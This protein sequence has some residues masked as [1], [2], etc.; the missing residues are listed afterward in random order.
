VGAVLL[1][2]AP[3][4]A[5]VLATGPAAGAGTP[6][7]ESHLI[8]KRAHGKAAID[9]LGSHLEV[10]AA[11]SSMTP[12]RLR[13]VLAEDSSAWVDVTGHLFYVERDHAADD[14]VAIPESTTES[15]T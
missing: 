13:R 8:A 6:R 2:V 11:R 14:P 15:T 4:C 7:A 3:I 10:A 9:A 5:A 1:L 12:A